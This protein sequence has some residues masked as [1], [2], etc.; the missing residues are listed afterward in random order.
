MPTF[1][2]ALE[3]GLLASPFREA[4]RSGP[5]LH[6]SVHP[7]TTTGS[8]QLFN[9]AWGVSAE[10]VECDAIRRR[11]EAAASPSGA[12]PGQGSFEDDIE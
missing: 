5:S 8:K 2:E 11:W 6:L 7:G 4:R 1:D 9:L 3:D 12:W 10:A